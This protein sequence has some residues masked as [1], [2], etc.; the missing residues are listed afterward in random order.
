[1]YVLL[2]IKGGRYSWQT[3]YTFEI[4]FKNAYKI[5]HGKGY[6]IDLKKKNIFD[7]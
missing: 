1:M 3:L 7:N 4:R 6:I 5:L 2:W